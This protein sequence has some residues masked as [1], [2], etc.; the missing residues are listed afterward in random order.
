MNN[1]QIRSVVTG[2]FLVPACIGTAI[3]Y[4]GSA[5]GFFTGLI[6]GLMWGGSLWML[7]A[8]ISGEV[9]EPSKVTR[10][11]IIGWFLGALIHTAYLLVSGEGESAFT[12]IS[13][14]LLSAFFLGGA[15]LIY[16]KGVP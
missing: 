15:V 5:E 2:L 6:G 7:Y 10:R 9:G 13:H 14:T 3:R 8:F 16:H 12:L 11:S 4:D 1:I